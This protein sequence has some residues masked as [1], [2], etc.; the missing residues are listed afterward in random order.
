M[1]VYYTDSRGKKILEIPVCIFF[2]LPT[3]ASAKWQGYIY[4]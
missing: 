2:V 1:R 3:I 4:L